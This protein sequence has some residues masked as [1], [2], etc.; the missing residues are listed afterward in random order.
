MIFKKFKDYFSKKNSLSKTDI[1]NIDG[2][3]TDLLD[4]LNISKNEV[5]IKY[6]LDDRCSKISCTIAFIDSDM[7]ISFINSDEVKNFKKRLSNEYILNIEIDKYDKEGKYLDKFVSL[8]LGHYNF[9]ITS[10]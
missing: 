2:L 9:E 8:D 3:V 7:I 4:D 1:D 5:K 10:K 6:K